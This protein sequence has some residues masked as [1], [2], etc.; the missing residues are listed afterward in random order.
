MPELPEDVLSELEGRPFPGN[1]RELEN[2]LLAYSAVGVLP[3][4]SPKPAGQLQQALAELLDV[5][6]PYAEQ[7]EEVVQQM[8]RIYLS[9]LMQHAGGNRSEAARV[10][11]LT[12]VPR[13][14]VIGWPVEHSRSPVI[15]RYW[16]EKYGID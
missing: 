10:A 2:A 6:R 11:G 14:C 4:A 13:A 8:T 3:D 7:K 16:L 1:V 15:H 5:N 9:L 12:M